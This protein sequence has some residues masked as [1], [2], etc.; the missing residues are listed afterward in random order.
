MQLLTQHRLL[1]LLPPLASTAGLSMATNMVQSA[2]A[3][4]IDVDALPDTKANIGEGSTVRELSLS[5]WSG[6]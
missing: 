5:S 1:D 4:V 2:A 3:I 6:T